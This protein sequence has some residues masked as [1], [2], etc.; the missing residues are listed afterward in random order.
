M[1]LDRCLRFSRLCLVLLALASPAAQGHDTEPATDGAD[2]RVRALFDT[3]EGDWAFNARVYSNGKWAQEIGLV[4]LKRT[5]PWRLVTRESSRTVQPDENLANEKEGGFHDSQ[6]TLQWD[7]KQQ[8]LVRTAHGRETLFELAGYGFRSD[9]QLPAGALA[10]IGVGDAVSLKELFV[11][12]GHDQF[13]NNVMATNASGQV[14]A[15]AVVVV[16]RIDTQ[17]RKAPL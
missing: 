5:G 10:G 17:V 2:Q 9:A 7:A 16:T 11:L 6:K 3:L 13:V 12:M 15:Q 4:T 8:K 14:V 1:S